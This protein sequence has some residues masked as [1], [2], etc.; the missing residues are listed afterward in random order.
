MPGRTNR[1][2][3]LDAIGQHGLMASTAPRLPVGTQVVLRDLAADHSGR[4]V[5]RG[6][7]GRVVGD[8]P[9]GSYA[10]KLSDGRTLG[11]ARDQL[12]LRRAYQQDLAVGLYSDPHQLVNDHTIYAVVVGSRAFGLS[13]DASDTDVR[14]VYV[15]PTADFWSLAKPPMHVEGPEDEWFSWEVESGFV[16]WR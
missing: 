3:P 14:G 16:S 9:D 2:N 8:Q 7:I 1:G 10:V 5:Q 13:T 15:A 4:P 11:A 12:S 6:A